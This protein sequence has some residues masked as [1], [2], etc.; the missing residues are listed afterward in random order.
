MTFF[1]SIT[2]AVQKRIRYT[3]TVNALKSLPLDVALDL[4]IYSGDAE[5]I[6]TQAVYG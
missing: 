3:R 1:N 4:D 6:A 2:D 5:K